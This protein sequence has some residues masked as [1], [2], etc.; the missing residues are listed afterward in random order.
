[1]SGV[2]FSTNRDHSKWAVT[3]SPPANS[4]TAVRPRSP[5]DRRKN[6]SRLWRQRVPRA[7]S[8]KAEAAAAVC[9]CDINREVSQFARGGGCLCVRNSALA[10]QFAEVAVSVEACS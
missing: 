6:R 7:T 9:V 1:M 4:S 2:Q 8:V 5:T 10:K 3:G